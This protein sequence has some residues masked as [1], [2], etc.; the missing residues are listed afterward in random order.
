[1]TPIPKSTLDLQVPLKEAQ[2][3][4]RRSEKT[5][6]G[7]AE[8]LPV[9]ENRASS[10]DGNYNVHHHGRWRL[11]IGM[12]RGLPTFAHDHNPPSISVSMIGH[13]RVALTH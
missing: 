5:R 8:F 12:A 6:S 13:P 1:M 10:R 3:D 9:S 2:F 4:F 11:R 7:A